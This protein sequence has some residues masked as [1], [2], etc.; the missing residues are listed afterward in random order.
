MIWRLRRLLTGID[1]ATLRRMQHSIEIS[2]EAAA[3]FRIAFGPGF[4]LQP[5]GWGKALGAQYYLRGQLPYQAGTTITRI[6][7][8][9]LLTFRNAPWRHLLL[10]GGELSRNVAYYSVPGGM[11]IYIY[12]EGVGEDND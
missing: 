9:L 3:G 4:S 2:G 10:R 6:D 7:S 11:V 8:T 5:S 1:P 12:V